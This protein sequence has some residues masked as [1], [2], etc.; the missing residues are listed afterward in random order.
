M[1][2]LLLIAAT[3]AVAN[4]ASAQISIAPEVGFQMTKVNGKTEGKSDNSDLKAGFRAGVN[5]DMGITNN[6][7][8]SAGLF[9][10]GMG[11]KEKSSVEYM[12]TTVSY[13]AK[14]N[15]DYLQLPIYLNYMTGEA[16]GNRFFAGIGPYLGYA[17]GGKI[18]VNDESQKIEFGSGD[19]AEM[20]RFDAGF[21][22]N[23]GYMLSMGLYA[24]AFYSMGLTNNYPKGNSDNSSK[25]MGFGLS[26]GYNLPF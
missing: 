3:A 24:R 20:K 13:E 12:G 6:I 11:G 16:G 5:A 7:H 26:I 14:M 9:Y 23:A 2:K 22:V 25:N 21:N 8:I 18:K 4:A 1:K 10:S 17:M 15:L 19:N